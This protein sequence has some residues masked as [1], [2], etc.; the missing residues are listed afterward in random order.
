MG[1]S[2]TTAT[3]KEQALWLLERVVPGIGINNLS[4]AFRVDGRI[5]PAAIEGA[6]RLLLR[7][8]EALR[9]VFHADGAVLRREVLPPGDLD[10]VVHWH[11]S[12][13]D[14]LDT[15]LVNFVAEPF[16]L[17]GGPLVRAA[18]F[19]SPAGDTVCVAVH[20]LVFDAT[21]S[22][23]L[24]GDLV[25]VYRSLAGGEPP[26]GEL[27]EPVPALRDPE[28]PD[29]SVAFWRE[30]LSG[31]RAGRLALPVDPRAEPGP[32]AAVVRYELSAE[33][34][35]VV[36]RM[37]EQLRV[38]EAV[39][40]LAVYYLLL[41]THGVGVDV[42]V[43]SPV[44]T[45]GR[46]SARAVGYH[47][48]LLAPR[49]ELDPA[50]SFR[51]LVTQVRRTFF[52]AMAHGDLSVD[53]DLADELPRTAPGRR[54]PLFR[55]VFNYVSEMGFPALDIG[56]APVRP[57]LVDN[58]YSKFD[59][60]L[61]VLP[62]AGR[63]RLE[64]SYR[65]ETFRRD[66]I[67]AMLRRYEAVLGAFGADVDQPVERVW[68]GTDEDRAV[69]DGAQRSATGTAS[70]V[71]AGVA[72]R[73]AATPGAVAI[74][75]GDRA[76]TYGQL[77]QAATATRDSL[78][79]SGLAGGDVVAV[80]APRGPELAAAALG[81]WLAGGAY[82]PV[83]LNYPVRHIVDVLSDSGA[84][85]VLGVD[86]V[87]VPN[88]PVYPVVQVTDTTTGDVATPVV[89]RSACA[90][91]LYT[92]PT[93]GRPV[94]TRVTH[95]NLANALAHLADEVGGGTTAWLSPFAT[96]M[97][98]AELFLP[99]VDGH[100][101]VVAPDEART[102]GAVLAEVLDDHE[103]RIVQATPTTWRRVLGGVADR[104]AG[105]RVLCGGESPRPGLAAA[106]AA[107][108]CEVFS[109]FG[110]DETTTYS[111]VGRV[112]PDDDHSSLAGRPVANTRLFVADEDGREVPPGVRGELCVAGAG[113]A[114]GYRNRQELATRR[115]AEHAGYGRYFRTGHEALL[116]YDG[117]WE[118]VAGP[119][120][121]V[122]AGGERIELDR[123]ERVL[124]R[125]GGVED[126][127]VV[128]VGDPD[129]DGAVVAFVVPE[130]AVRRVAD[131]VVLGDVVGLPGLPTTVDDRVDYAALV[132][133]A[134]SRRIEDTGRAALAEGAVGL[135]PTMLSLWRLLLG[136]DDLDS[137]SNFFVAG[138][139][140]LLAA[141]LA[142]R[143]EAITGV[144]LPLVEVFENPTPSA[145]AEKVAALLPATDSDLAPVGSETG[146]EGKLT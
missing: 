119:G 117:E 77:W 113:V 105:R 131:A 70:T 12:S 126:V 136:R 26:A 24:F 38:P 47:V 100:R 130:T 8:Y 141:Q 44:N 96:G 55:Y 81:V 85:A 53:S 86:G 101:A 1:L 97:S 122:V 62:S 127:A 120:R 107:T 16:E 128:M 123:L 31:H 43:G 102:D 143:V 18:C 20:H 83:D 67:A 5:D 92:S 98:A 56:G 121:T 14:R 91:L 129:T 49:V 3:R 65:A 6:I 33:T 114:L 71:L 11:R 66:D 109:F 108:G 30:H 59:L 144:P 78:V 104:L 84:T 32:F 93:M 25:S 137:E 138:G 35:E 57:V 7:R 68:A 61:F 73:V 40:L 19:H 116:R 42:V 79:A 76:V 29:S 72:A 63:I 69:I 132:R 118:L 90:F 135:A 133:L 145:L 52:A 146:P 48:N 17:R 39:L 60:V 21:S 111:I 87:E 106:L 2:E 9:T 13:A 41:A 139:Y 88:L 58:P 94:G 110:T 23:I 45:R 89:D 27:C 115:F 15:D 50:R 54:E 82:V 4:V 142:E 95:G 37:R 103:V 124:S 80:F 34:T 22:S 46:L 10:V 99:L 28:P 134:F 74:K 64:A 125:V 112:G 36:E 140:S 75:D 51:D